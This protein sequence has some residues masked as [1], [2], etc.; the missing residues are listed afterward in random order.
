[1]KNLKELLLK[2]AENQYAE[3][4]R[5]GR[6]SKFPETVFDEIYE[7]YVQPNETDFRQN[8]FENRR[9][10]KAIE[11]EECILE[12]IPIIDREYL[13]VDIKNKQFYGLFNAV[14]YDK[15]KT[16]ELTISSLLI[17]DV[18]NIR[19]IICA[20]LEKRWLVVYLVLNQTTKMFSSFLKLKEFFEIFPPNIKIFETDVEMQQYFENNPDA[21]LPKTIVAPEKGKYEKILEDIHDNR[22]RNNI[23]SNN[24]FLSIC[25]PS[26]NRGIRALKAVNYALNSR[27]DSE[28]E[29]VL[30]NNGSTIETEQYQQIKNIIDSRL[31]YY[32]Y[33]KNGGYEVS[34]I[35]CLK[36]T[37]GH[38]A[39]MVS[40]ED[41]WVPDCLNNVLEYLFEHRDI[42]GCTFAA[43]NNSDYDYARPNVGVIEKGVDAVIWAHRDFGYF[44]G[45][46]Y[47]MNYVR[48]WS[49]FDQ[50]EKYNKG[51]NYWKYIQNIF[52]SLLG[53]KAPVANSGIKAWLLGE[54]ESKGGGLDETLR[55]DNIFEYQMPEKRCE[56]L[57]G[58]MELAN[59]VL[60]AAGL[61]KFLHFRLNSIMDACT[62]CCKIHGLKYEEAIG[63]WQ[64]LCVMIYK[65]CLRILKDLKLEGSAALKTEIDKSFFY[66]LVC[67]RLQKKHRPEENLLPSLQAQVVKYYYDKKI[68]IEKIDFQKI[69]N[70]L[71]EWVKDFLSRE[72]ELPS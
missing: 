24:V 36:N 46:C 41:F 25:I 40:D 63:S 23:P 57:E 6:I 70:D 2:N 71:G 60:D 39:V 62:L 72:D 43:L 52:G 34:Y 13:I 18:W 5:W 19:E 45:I 42:A 27:Y 3:L 49:I 44:S 37:C 31:H 7:K 28:I 21:Y 30:V 10:W 53:A 56:Q 67:K 15:N 32:E 22:I 51:T 9:V 20:A 50:I 33:E 66:W 8:Y 59:D 47:N 68:P 58:S 14:S 11:Y 48:E 12:F 16:L 54:T 69:N 35:N 26:Y 55:D 29:I 64:E 17:A 1:M 61:E 38:F 4:D 65:T